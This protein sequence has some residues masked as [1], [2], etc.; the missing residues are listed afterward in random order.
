MP[1]AQEKRLKKALF[2]KYFTCPGCG[3]AI[4]GEME[5]YFICPNCGK[6]IC[7]ENEVEK[8]DYD[9]CINCGY[10]ITSAKK[11]ALAL[12]VEED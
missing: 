2:G 10:E 1:D 5:T 4:A 12:V 3:R 9:Y 8:L 6:A 11:K 7:K